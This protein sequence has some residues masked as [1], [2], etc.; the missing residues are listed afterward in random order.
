MPEVYEAIGKFAKGGAAIATERL[1]SGI[2][3]PFLTLLSRSR[4][5]GSGREPL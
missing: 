3:P 5:Q 4:R 1:R 2:A